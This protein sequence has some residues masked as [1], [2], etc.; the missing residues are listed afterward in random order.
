MT[1]RIIPNSKGNLSKEVHSDKGQ[2]ASNFSSSRVAEVVEVSNSR[3]VVE[4]EDSN[5]REV[6]AFELGS[7]ECMH[8]WES[9]AHEQSWEAC[10]LG[11]LLYVL[12]SIDS[13]QMPLFSRVHFPIKVKK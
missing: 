10:C 13:Y 4:A 1:I 8:R 9:Q 5:S 6:L 7:I 12:C 11:R 3:A 2:E